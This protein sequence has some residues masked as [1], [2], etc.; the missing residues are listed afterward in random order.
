MKDAFPFW[1]NA[2]IFVHLKLQLPGTQNYILEK[3]L[4]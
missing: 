3:T 4:F 2:L 1:H